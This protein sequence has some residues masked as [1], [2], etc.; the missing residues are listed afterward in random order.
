MAREIKASRTVEFLSCTLG[1]L[2]GIEDG[3]EKVDVVAVMTMRLEPGSFSPTNVHLQEAEA[4]RLRDD[5]M[6]LFPRTQ[7]PSAYW[8]G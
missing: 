4:I 1:Q 7:Y 2:K 8:D 5:L 3:K 6:R